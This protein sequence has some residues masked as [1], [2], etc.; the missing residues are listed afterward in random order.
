[1]KTKL[2]WLLIF[3]SVM[4]RSLAQ[5]TLALKL[6]DALDATIKDNAEVLLATLDQE[7]AKAKFDQTNAVF[8]PQVNLSY[9]ALVTN[10]PLNAFGFK[11]QQQSVAPA[12]FNPQLLTLLCH[13]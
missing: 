6:Q 9:T 8:L 5:D 10:N 3:M 12:D 2:L 13:N 11:L 1:M 4:E 7:N